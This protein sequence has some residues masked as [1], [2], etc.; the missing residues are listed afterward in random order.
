MRRTLRAGSGR[1]IG[2]RAGGRGK[3]RW[4]GGAGEAQYSP[5]RRRR[6]PPLGGGRGAS[7]RG[8]AI[9]K[10]ARLE[11]RTSQGWRMRGRE[12]RAGRPRSDK[13]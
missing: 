4:G 7:R 11:S 9:Q 8:G 13:G 2:G 1:G 3:R 6:H 10:R 5:R 12:K